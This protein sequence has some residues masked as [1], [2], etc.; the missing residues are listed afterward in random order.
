MNVLQRWQSLNRDQRNAVYVMGALAITTITV[1]GITSVLFLV[2]KNTMDQQYWAWAP[3]GVSCDS[4]CHTQCP[5][6][7]CI[8]NRMQGILTRSEFRAANMA[9]RNGKRACKGQ[10]FK[11]RKCAGPGR[12]K[13]TKYCHFGCRQ[14]NLCLYVPNSANQMLCA[15][16]CAQ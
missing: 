14:T 15:C 3:A 9:A 5:Q 10:S 13:K 2:R 12:N 4:F 11:C 16:D 7:S 8:N 6:G 1:V